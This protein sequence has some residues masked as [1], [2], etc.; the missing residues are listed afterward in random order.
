MVSQ[1]A[2]TPGRTAAVKFLSKRSAHGD[3]AVSAVKSHAFFGN[4]IDV[5]SLAVWVAIDT[6][7][8]AIHIVREDE[9]KV[10]WLRVVV[11]CGRQ[12]GAGK[13]K[14]KCDS[15]KQS[16]HRIAGERGEDTPGSPL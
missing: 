12:S 9:Y 4:L 13:Q 5:G 7:A 10:G 14:A 16:S 11:F 15:G 1:C 6:P 3:A 8:I 2:C